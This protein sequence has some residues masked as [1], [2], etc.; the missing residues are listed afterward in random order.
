MELGQILWQETQQQFYLHITKKK[1]TQIKKLTLTYSYISK[2]AKKPLGSLYT[3]ITFHTIQRTRKSII[4]IYARAYALENDRATYC[5]SGKNGMYDDYKPI[6]VHI[7]MSLWYFYCTS[8][9]SYLFILFLLLHTHT[10]TCVGTHHNRINRLVPT[11]SIPSSETGEDRIYI[12]N[13]IKCYNSHKSSLNLS[14][15]F[16]KFVQYYTRDT[17][18]RRITICKWF[19]RH[20]LF[21]LF[22]L[23]IYFTS[24]FV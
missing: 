16:D 4:I 2:L 9:T 23:F 15:R 22:G 18:R 1:Y 10:H 14:F 13:H 8:L 3:H 20:E 11:Y 12:Y 5:T 7:T 21:I 17:R 24:F 19:A 6:S